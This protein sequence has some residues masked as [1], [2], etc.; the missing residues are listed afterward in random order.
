ML[1][2]YEA[3]IVGIHLFVISKNLEH[4][5]LYTS[6]CYLF[7]LESSGIISHTRPVELLEIDKNKTMGKSRK[8]E[9]I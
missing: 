7:F 5:F 4:L 3:T 9:G 2:L 6:D 8:V 1:H